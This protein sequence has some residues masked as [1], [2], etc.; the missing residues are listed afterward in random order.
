MHNCISLAAGS[1]PCQ[2]SVPPVT[3]PATAGVGP[4]LLPRCCCCFVSSSA[5][6]DWTTR[7]LLE[8]SGALLLLHCC[9][10]GRGNVRCKIR[11]CM[12]FSVMRHDGF[13]HVCRVHNDR[14]VEVQ[15]SFPNGRVQRVCLHCIETSLG[16]SR[17]QSER[18]L[19]VDLSAACAPAAVPSSAFQRG[20]S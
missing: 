7:R 18:S 12:R 3:G 2:T 1:D 5:A 13:F 4:V 10:K 15:A 11:R 14:K 8:R 9:W 19:E 20:S 16:N 6:A 17:L